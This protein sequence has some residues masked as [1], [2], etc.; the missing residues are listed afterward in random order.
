VAQVRESIRFWRASLR[1]MVRGSCDPV[2]TMGL[3]KPRSMKDRALACFQDVE[4]DSYT[5]YLGR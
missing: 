4:R 1:G 3:R 2:I 5:M